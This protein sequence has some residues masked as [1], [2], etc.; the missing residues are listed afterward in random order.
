VFVGTKRFVGFGDGTPLSLRGRARYN[1]PRWRLAIVL[2]T[3][4]S[5]TGVGVLLEFSWDTRAGIALAVVINLR[6][7]ASAKAASGRP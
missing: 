3:R 5:F 1:G 2:Q 6:W 4:R 7:R